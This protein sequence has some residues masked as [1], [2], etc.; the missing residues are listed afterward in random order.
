MT[1]DPLAVRRAVEVTAGRTAVVF[2]RLLRRSLDEVRPEGERVLLVMA[3]L[4]TDAAAS[5]PEASE[6]AKARRLVEW[7][8]WQA[9]VDTARGR[10]CRWAS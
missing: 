6:T 1:F 8:E 4:N 2:A 7:I 9:T 5:L 3:N 10:I